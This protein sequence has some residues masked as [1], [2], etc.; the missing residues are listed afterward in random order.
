MPEI[1]PKIPFAVMFHHFWDGSKHKYIQGALRSDEFEDL[2]INSRSHKFISADIWLEKLSNKTLTPHETCVTFDD[3]LLSQYDIAKPILNKL[4]LKAIWFIYSSACEGNSDDFEVYRYF[5]N[6]GFESIDNFHQ[7]FFENVSIVLSQKKAKEIQRSKIAKNYFIE[8]TLY[9][10]IER[11]FRY[12]R[13]QIL[14]PY[15][16]RQVM[17]HMMS[18]SNFDIENIK[19]TISLTNN[20]LREL[21]KD[22]D[23]IG[24]HSFSHPVNFRRLNLEEQVSEYFQNAMHLYKILGHSPN[25]MAHPSNSYDETTLAILRGMGVKFGFRSNNEFIGKSELELPRI[26]HVIFRRMINN[27]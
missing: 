11:V 14:T 26:D 20:E 2:L 9:S 19:K 27:T 8:H 7:N 6:L 3:A 25:V 15:E 1:Q 17:D 18:K 4:G 21:H 24:L 22:R 12:F 16:F 10:E 5:R 13:D 23:I